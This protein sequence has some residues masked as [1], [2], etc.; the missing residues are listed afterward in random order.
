MMDQNAAMLETGQIARV[1]QRTYL[2]E[3]VVKAA[4]V[5]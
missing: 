1:R 4:S 5:V 3:E 2:V